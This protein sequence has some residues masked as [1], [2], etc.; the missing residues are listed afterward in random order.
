MKHL[1]PCASR[2][3]AALALVC[4]S[5]LAAAGPVTPFDLKDGAGTTY[6]SGAT[7]LDWNAQGSG[8]AKGIGPFS[9]TTLIPA[10]TPFQFLY[11]ANMVTAGGGTPTI[12][13]AGLDPTSNGTVD[14]GKSFEFTIVAKLNEVVTASTFVGGNPTAV[15]G[16]GGTNATNKL[17]IYYDPA[18]NS[19]TSAGTGFDD[20]ILVAMFT[21]DAGEPGF[22]TQSTFTALNG[23]GT[24]QGSA[25]IHASV[26]E[27]GDFV[28]TAYLAGVTSIDFDVHYQSNLNYPAGSSTTSAF[29]VGGDAATFPTYA[30]GANDILF[31]VDG[32][33]QFG[34]TAVPEPGT[35]M[36][37]GIGMLGLV[38]AGRRW[39]APKA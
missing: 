23:T 33:N 32:D 31:K 2:L 38:G 35:M 36:L 29:H 12:A 3:A 14:A 21:I 34:I 27:P 6:V 9:D 39:Q 15:F 25:R 22:P 28:N 5:G 16:L 24:G 17:A 37:L 11:Q 4:A 13:F 19:L 10:G 30:V 8:V 20:G 7:S 18:A 1:P 26:I